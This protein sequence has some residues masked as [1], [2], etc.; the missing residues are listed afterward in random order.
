MSVME[1]RWSSCGT[2]EATGNFDGAAVG[3]GIVAG[4]LLRQGCAGGIIGGDF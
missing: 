4:G 2:A 3:H 1:S